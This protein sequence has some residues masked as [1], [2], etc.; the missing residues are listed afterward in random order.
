[1]KSKL[2]LLS[3]LVYLSACVQAMT[4]SGVVSDDAGPLPG[5]QIFVVGTKKG[6]ITDI[7]GEYSIEV[8]KGQVLKF[9]FLGYTTKTVKV[10]TS[11]V[12][13]KLE[14]ERRELDEMVIVSAEYRNVESSKR[15]ASVAH[16]VP[17]FG[18]THK[19]N[20]ISPSDYESAEEY[21]SFVDNGFKSPSKDPLSTFSI[22]VDAA[23]Y[24]NMRRMINQGYMPNMDAIRTEEMVNYFDYDYAQPKGNDPVKVSAEIG[25]CPWNKK[26]RLVKLGLKAKEIDKELLPAS[27]LVFLIDVSGSMGGATRIDLVKSSMRLLLNNLRDIDNVSVVTYASGVNVRLEST[28]GA[29]KAKIKSV[30]DGLVASGATSGGEAIQLAYVQAKKNFKKDGNN[31]IILCTDGDFNIG[32]SSPEELTKLIEKERN[33]GVYLSIL[34]YGMGNYKDNKMQALAQ[35]GNGNHAYID[36]IQ[37]AN[38]VLVKEFGSTMYTIAKDVKLQVEFNPAK[39]K[40]YRLIGYETRL[41]EAEDFNDDK[42][43]AGEMGVGHTVTAMYEVVPVGVDSKVFDVDPLKYQ[44]QIANTYNN[45]SGELLTVKMRYKDIDSSKSKMLEQ[46]IVDEG[47][48][49]VSS[50]FNFAASVVMCSQLLRDSAYKGDASYDDVIKLARSSL[51]K[52]KDGY[53]S[54]FVRL[55][56]SMKGLAE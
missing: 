51:G 23:S 7:D 30:I 10:S 33:S 25:Q 45:K 54:E 12:N 50:D 48:N 4:V 38:K 43:D 16:F 8:E 18:Y 44:K 52:D 1:M 19:P 53:R 49:S 21:K 9:T 47:G 20:A 55:V 15:T 40:A 34:G 11:V 46:A 29:D 14:A 6:T 27:N 39:V 26:H 13:V 3:I 31:R 2:F 37:E 24:S 28:S 35:A 32:P 56:E 41:L 42:K 5:V 22:D 17:P 36:N